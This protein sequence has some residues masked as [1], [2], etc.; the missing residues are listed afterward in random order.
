MNLI[1]N[2]DDLGI[3]GQV[4][5][6]IFALMSKKL[7]TSSTLIANA[8]AIEDACRRL[9]N[10][11]FCS[12]GIHLNITEFQ[13]LTNSLALMPLLDQNGGLSLEKLRTT[14]ISSRLALGIFEEFCAQIES[15]QGVG[16]ELSHIDSHHYVHTIPR[17]LP[18]VKRVQ[19]KFNI[20]KIRLTRNIYGFD[21]HPGYQSR[22]K[23]YM[24]NRWLRYFP[25]SK[26]TE[27]F[28]NF[29]LFY[30][31]AC[32]SRM[33]FRTFEAVVHPGSQYYGPEEV[34]L[35]KG[36]WQDDILFPVRL[37]SYKDVS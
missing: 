25:L 1:I 17:L 15:L 9:K 8:P 23:K 31:N 35:L 22:L 7:V 33:K 14:N 4:N 10:Y 16:I 18:V 37:V 12:F 11:S 34:E 13:P 24:F 20:R 32:L 28:G 27:G 2:A 36:N 29:K 21:E 19:K 3:N 5:N 6:D 30:E 26:T